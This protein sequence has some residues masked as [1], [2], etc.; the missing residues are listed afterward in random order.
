MRAVTLYLTGRCNLRC[1]HCAVGADQDEHRADPGTE[2]LKA[3]LSGIAEGGGKYVTL[4]GGEATIYRRDLTELLD[5]AETIGLEVS[6]NTNA[7]AYP[8][9][10]ALLDKPALGTLVV[11][12]DGASPATHDAMRGARTFQRTL[13]TLSRIISHPRVRAGRLA[14]EI[15]YVISRLNHADTGR[16]V[17]LAI[18]LGVRR[19]NAKHVKLTGRALDHAASLEL[20]S[21]ELLEAYSTL[22]MTWVASG[23]KIEL[24][25]HVPPALAYYLRARFGLAYPIDDHP[26]CGGIGEF[27]YVDLVGN[28]L[29]CPA[30][31]YEEDTASGMKA[32]RPDLSLALRPA[33]EVHATPLFA[34]FENRRRRRAHRDRLFPCRIC[35]FNDLSRPCTADLVKGDETAEIDIC[36]AVFDCGDSEVPGVRADVFPGEAASVQNLQKQAVID[37]F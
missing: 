24:D 16:M 34:D 15:S 18:D 35:R 36:K 2:E 11:S 1:R 4:L 12:L 3:I 13:A 9:L 6:I 33:A 20:A 32:L 22:L 21:E 25:V 14:I 37:A 28:Y 31:S 8:P 27:G 5:H 19:L 17:M 23:K 30:M 7:T 10:S 29:P 26:A